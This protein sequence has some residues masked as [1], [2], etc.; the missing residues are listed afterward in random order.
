MRYIVTNVKDAIAFYT[1]KL[2]FKVDMHPAPGF[3]ALS[4]DNI[5]LFLN[6]P[7]AGGAGQAMNDGAMPTPGGWNRFQL[8]TDNLESLVTEL[9]GKGASFRSEVM[10][11][12]GGKQ[13]LL[14][15]PSGNLIELFEPKK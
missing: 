4:K 10:V 15:D 11:G 7:G 13:A 12:Q 9:K 8:E 2:G 6:Q 1:E 3:A 14:Q 5:K